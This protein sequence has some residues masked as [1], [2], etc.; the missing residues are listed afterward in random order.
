LIN[1]GGRTI[2]EP[3][4]IQ[5]TF[6]SLTPEIISDQGKVIYGI[7]HPQKIFCVR[8]LGKNEKTDLMATFVPLSAL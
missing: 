8:H 7:T 6:S 5:S 1:R 2:N 4:P 3:F